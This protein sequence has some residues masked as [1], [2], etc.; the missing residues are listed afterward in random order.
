MWLEHELHHN[1]WAGWMKVVVGRRLKAGHKV[2]VS[3]QTMRTRC[4]GSMMIKPIGLKQA[5]HARGQ[6]RSSAGH[7]LIDGLRGSI[8]ANGSET[9]PGTVGPTRRAEECG[10]RI[11]VAANMPAVAP[12]YELTCAKGGVRLSINA[13]TIHACSCLAVASNPGGT[14]RRGQFAHRLRI[15]PQPPRHRPCS[16][17]CSACK[18]GRETTKR[19]KSRMG[20][21]T[22]GAL[23]C[24]LWCRP[25]SSRRDAERCSRP[26]AKPFRIARGS[27][28]RRFADTANTPDACLRV[29]DNS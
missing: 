4:R 29:N 16:C 19:P 3:E 25:P 1:N 10:C 26:S 18:E 21:R 11:N 8:E 15:R 24:S 20:G 17:S 22:N 27:V 6:A 2:G 7:Y 14:S 13:Y 9:K 23:G 5:C 28:E 12:S